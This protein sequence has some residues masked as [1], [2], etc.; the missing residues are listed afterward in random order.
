MMITLMGGNL[1]DFVT[2]ISTINPLYPL[3]IYIYNFAAAT[4]IVGI[5]AGGVG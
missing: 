4:F 3:F 5:F 2:D 1:P